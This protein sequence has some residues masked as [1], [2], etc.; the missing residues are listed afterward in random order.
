M[1][2][3]GNSVAITSQPI[4]NLEIEKEKMTTGDGTPQ[5]YTHKS[6][7]TQYE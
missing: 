1:V 2:P 3:G 7:L 4:V 5:D 6:G